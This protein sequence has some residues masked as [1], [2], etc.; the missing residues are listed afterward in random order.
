M[1]VY[2]GEHYLQF[3]G[4]KAWFVK[5]GP[6]GPED[7][8]GYQDFDATSNNPIKKSDTINSPSIN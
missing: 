5:A 1:L 3:Q 8:F 6:G 2:V 7:F 4:S